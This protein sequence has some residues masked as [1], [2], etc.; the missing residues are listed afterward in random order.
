[1]NN[2]NLCP[3]W[4]QNKIFKQALMFYSVVFVSKIEM[5]QVGVENGWMVCEIWQSDRI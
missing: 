2:S 1:M 3:L 4:L 5:M